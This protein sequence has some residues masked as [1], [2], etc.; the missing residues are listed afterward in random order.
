V[1]CELGNVVNAKS[2]AATN[3]IA[4]SFE[5]FRDVC[6]RGG[7]YQPRVSGV[8]PSICVLTQRVGMRRSGALTLGAVLMLGGVT[9]GRGDDLLGSV[10]AGGP[11]SFGGFNLPALP[12]NWSDL[13]VQAE[14]FRNHKLQQ[15]H[16]CRSDRD[17]LAEWRVFRRLYLD[18]VLRAF[19]QS[20]LV[21]TTVFLQR[22]VR[23]DT[24]SS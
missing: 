8:C 13:P 4:N 21:W 15:Q 22:H 14:R 24:L 17:E 10:V 7:R 9:A 16:F 6:D 18:V 3:S 2:R 19:D 12:E 5:T 23:S 20:Q 1:G 11:S